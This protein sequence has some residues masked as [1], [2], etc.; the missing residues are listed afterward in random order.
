M[1]ER[2][3]N[4]IYHI[5]RKRSKPWENVCCWQ[6]QPCWGQPQI[7]RNAEPS[8]YESGSELV[9]PSC[10]P[11]LN[12]QAHVF[13]ND[14]LLCA[15]ASNC[16]FLLLAIH[17]LRPFT[18]ILILATSP[19]H[20]PTLVLYIINTLKLRVAGQVVPLPVYRVGTAHLTPA[21]LYMDL[22]FLH[23]PLP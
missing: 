6:A 4:I 15:K 2:T 11:S 8:P 18:L 5:Y 17:C 3:N 1:Y 14:W 13:T 23:F 21:C 7:H 12:M 22:L 20:P 9:Q 10:A 16:R 19:P